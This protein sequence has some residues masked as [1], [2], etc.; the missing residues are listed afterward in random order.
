[1]SPQTTN[2]SLEKAAPPETLFTVALNHPSF[3]DLL[4]YF[5][6]IYVE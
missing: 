1:M 6:D 5:M 2:C 3:I 4:K